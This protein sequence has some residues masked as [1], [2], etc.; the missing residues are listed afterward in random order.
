[1]N[2]NDSNSKKEKILT[3]KA[4]DPLQYDSVDLDWKKDGMLDSPMRQFFQE[5]LEQNIEDLT[6]KNVIDIGSGTGHL[7][8]LFHK[9]GAKEIYGIE[10]SHKNVE[11]SRELYPEMIVDEVGLEETRIKKTF[12]VAIVVMAFEHM[13]NLNLSFQRIAQLL[14]PAGIFYAIVGDKEYFTTERFGYTL[15]IEDLGNGEVAVATGRPYGV[16]HDILRPI[17][18]FI[19]AARKNG[20]FLTKNISLTPTKKIIQVEAKYKQ[21]KS[22]SL[23]HLLV[24][25]HD[26]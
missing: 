21:F 19:E 23:G 25:K 6:D 2:S 9:F 18:S 3:I 13:R 17:S 24:F 4:T 12:D 5:Y 15:K 1:M 16:I 7:T 11:I 22:K 20:L 10:P 14:K 26:R 8:K